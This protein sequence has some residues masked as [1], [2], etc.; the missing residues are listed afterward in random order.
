MANGTMQLPR[1]HHLILE[2]CK[3]LSISGVNDIDSFDERAV[4]LHTEN[5]VLEIRGENLHIGL[6]DVES[7]ELTMDGVVRAMIY[8]EEEKHKKQQSFWSRLFR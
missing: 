1:A 3:R 5:D 6:L 7:G 8:Q 4:M 2:D